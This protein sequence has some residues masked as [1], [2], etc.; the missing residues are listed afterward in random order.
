[1]LYLDSISI[2]YLS[3][4]MAVR[5]KMDAVQANTSKA[6]H[7]SHSRS[8]RPQYFVTCNEKKTNNVTPEY[9]PPHV[10]PYTL[11]LE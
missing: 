3:T 2:Y 1:M 5:F 6:T 11:T 10:K 7:A 4:L 8:L 9:A